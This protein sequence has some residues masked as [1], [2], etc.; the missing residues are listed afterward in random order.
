ML[1]TNKLKM[2]FRVLKAMISSGIVYE[3]IFFAR[4]SSQAH[5]AGRNDCTHSLAWFGRTSRAMVR[6]LDLVDE[7][8]L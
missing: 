2:S 7:N 6:E 1:G 4:N 5:L 8:I 3:F